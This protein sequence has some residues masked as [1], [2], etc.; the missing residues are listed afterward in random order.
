T[1]V[2]MRRI[3]RDIADDRH[4]YAQVQL[5]AALEE[6]VRARTRDL[7]AAL[8]MLSIANARLTGARREAEQARNDLYAALEAVQHGFALFDPE[9]RLILSNSRFSAQLPDVAAQLGTG[10]SFADY[11]RLLSDSPHM[12]LPD[13]PTRA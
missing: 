12:E 13:W 1:G 6:Q 5:A 7:D 10:L 3:E 9:D 8:Q 2:L 11:V 4:G